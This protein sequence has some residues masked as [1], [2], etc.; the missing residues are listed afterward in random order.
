MTPSEISAEILKKQHTEE[1]Y[2]M[3]Y[4]RRKGDIIKYNF[5]P[6]ASSEDVNFFSASSIWSLAEIKVRSTQNAQYFLTHGPFLEKKKYDGLCTRAKEILITHGFLPNVYYFNFC[7]DKLL[8]YKLDVG[9]IHTWKKI[10]LPRNNVT[11]ELVEKE[12]TELYSPI[13]ILSYNA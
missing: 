3:A 8:I 6:L 12:V 13:E 10:Q 2:F 7:S 4:A 5:T 11:R 9:V 1:L